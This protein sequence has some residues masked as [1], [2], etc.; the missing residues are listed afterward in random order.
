[1]GICCQFNIDNL[2]G[3]DVFL[4]KVEA[5]KEPFSAVTM[6]LN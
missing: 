4:E 2:G 5:A 6:V 1:M 3:S